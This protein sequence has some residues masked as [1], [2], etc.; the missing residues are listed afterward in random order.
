MCR[1]PP[2]DRGKHSTRLTT[3][4]RAL[5]QTST[6]AY[7]SFVA[8]P[9]SSARCAN[10]IDAQLA[11]VHCSPSSSP[12][13]FHTPSGGGITHQ[14]AVLHQPGSLAAPKRP[15][16]H[17]DPV[18]L[19]VGARRHRADGIVFATLQQALPVGCIALLD[20]GLAEL[21]VA[22]SFDRYRRSRLLA[23]RTRAG[24]FNQASR[25]AR[26]SLKTCAMA[27]E[28][29]TSSPLSQARRTLLV[30]ALTTSL[31]VRACS[32]DVPPV[33]ADAAPSGA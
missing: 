18:L 29:S 30:Y 21:D 15:D 3:I 4:T 23:Y 10:G 28:R 7:A 11:C 19:H 27:C 12:S 16:R 1:V 20:P 25:S 17:L 6:N 33:G 32:S 8:K 5:R 2:V 26:A 13:R 14:Y 24:Q 9:V 31:T 22:E